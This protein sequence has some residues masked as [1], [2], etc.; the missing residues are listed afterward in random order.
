MIDELTEGS[1]P[2]TWNAF[3]GSFARAASAASSSL[4]KSVGIGLETTSP[5]TI[6]RVRFHS[7]S[8]TAGILSLGER[9]FFF[10]YVSE[11]RRMIANITY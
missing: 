5:P 8:S 9:V 2:R 3:S 10:S 6:S 1:S 11:P 7:A 4:E